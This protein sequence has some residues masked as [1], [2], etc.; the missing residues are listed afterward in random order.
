[1]G[2]FLTL[3]AILENPRSVTRRI[4]RD[5]E[6]LTV[7]PLGH[8]DTAMLCDYFDRLSDRTKDWF[9][10]HEFTHEVAARLCRDL[11]SENTLRLVA[12]TES[13]APRIVAYFILQ[14]GLR[15]PERERFDGYGVALPDETTCSLAPSVADAYQN[16]GL[17]SAILEQTVDV[18][19]RAGREKMILF[20]GVGLQNP[21]AVH[22]YRKFGFRK[23]PADA[24]EDRKF[25]MVLDVVPE[26]E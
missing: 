5:D 1:M 12:V 15:P 7:R 4:E 9:A 6:T 16:T 24:P 21:R 18:A 26:E 8:S 14:F 19:R 20:G 10:P 22:F 13:D 25:D 11:L 2:E 23:V 17:G 3:Q